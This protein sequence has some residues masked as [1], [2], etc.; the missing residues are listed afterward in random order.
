MKETIEYLKE[1]E[2]K[3]MLAVHPFVDEDSKNYKDLNKKGCLADVPEGGR[4][5]FDHT[6]PKTKDEMWKLYQKL[7]DDGVA[8]WWTDMGEPESDLP[9]T[10]AYAGKR[11]KYHNI[12]TLLWS[13]NINEAQKENTGTRNF[14]LA[15][16][17]A[18]LQYRLLDRRY[19]CNL[20]N[21]QK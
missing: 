6:N 18:K 1:M 4:P 13:K 15:R 9:G 16:T 7:H 17:N 5:Y 12:Y 10:K 19:I 11:E 20:G 2:I 8:A 21:I 3:V 14:C